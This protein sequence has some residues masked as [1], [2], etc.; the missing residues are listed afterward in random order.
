[1]T[2][3]ARI[4]AAAFVG[5]SVSP[6]LAETLFCSTSFQGYRV[7]DDGH[8]YR[9]TERRWQGL[10]IGQDSD[11]SRWTTAEGGMVRSPRSRARS[12]EP[13]RHVASAGRVRTGFLACRAR[14]PWR[15]GLGQRDWNAV[16]R[17][18]LGPSLFPPSATV[19]CSARRG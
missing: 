16:L 15:V 11:G 9:S 8:G 13:R 17:G 19:L 12:A 4:I 6:A 3:R 7:C 2:M 10:T 14:S 1:M 5:V 18:S